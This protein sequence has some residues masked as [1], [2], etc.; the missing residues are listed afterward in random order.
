MDKVKEVTLW[1]HSREDK[2]NVIYHREYTDCVATRVV[3]GFVGQTML[4]LRTTE[5]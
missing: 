1:F 3:A 5:M 2:N 4:T